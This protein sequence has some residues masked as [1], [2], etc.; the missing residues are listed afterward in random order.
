M[1]KVNEQT[2]ISHLPELLRLV[3]EVHASQ[4]PR[5]LHRRQEALAVLVPVKAPRRALRSETDRAAFL[6]AAGG[7]KDVDTDRLIVDIY[8]DREAGDR[9]PVE[10]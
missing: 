4:Q 2:D 9:P 7:W 10:L 8:A 6:S 3:E 5:V 1:A